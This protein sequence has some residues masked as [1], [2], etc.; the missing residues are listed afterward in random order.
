MASTWH[1]VLDSLAAQIELQE[2]ALRHG[3]PGPVDLVVDP[4]TAP[5]GETERLRAIELFERCEQMLDVA[6]DRIVAA[7]RLRNSPYGTAS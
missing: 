2:R 7:R 6:T 4:P 3:H 1:D 5:M